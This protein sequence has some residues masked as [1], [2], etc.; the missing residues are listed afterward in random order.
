MRVLIIGGGGRE[1][2]LAWKLG[3]SPRLSELF[4]APGNAGTAE[5]AT[6]MPGEQTASGI[7]IAAKAERIDLVVVGPDNALAEGIVDRLAEAGI[8]AFGPTRAAAR[9]EWSKSFA[10]ELMQRHGIPTAAYATFEDA[11]AALRYVRKQAEPPVI[12]ADGLALGKGVVVATTREEAEAAVRAAMIEGA[13]GA[14][15]GRVVIEERMRGREASCH[16]IS[17][18]TTVLALPF[19]R[20]Y[21]R[22]LD[23]DGGANTGGM[24]AYSPLEDIDAALGERV[25]RTIAE[26]AI[27]AMAAEGA[28]FR[29]LLYP[30]LMLTQEGP[31]VI[32]FNSRFGDPETQVLMPRLEGDLLDLL[33]RSANG[34]L[35]GATVDV[36][37]RAAVGVVMASGGYPGPYRTGMAIEGL[38]DVDEDALV[39]HAGTALD[40]AGRVVTSGGRVLTV[41]AMGAT[42]AEARA[43]AY[44]NVGRIRFEG[45]QYRRD[46]A[47]QRD[48]GPGTLPPS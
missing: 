15:G 46:I 13:F 1:H 2:A 36:S 6:N 47:S 5:L 28:P 39:F 41:V 44:D 45:A 29:G 40:S 19:S 4:V 16:V 27:R 22:A 11:E 31:K 12:K 20:D 43:K 30:G 23:G 33:W 9:I 21:K 42:V 17:D 24:G 34:T 14:S 25:L 10:K 38:T 37:P 48:A 8:P 18:G 3:Q 26:P 7:V 35:A 32:E